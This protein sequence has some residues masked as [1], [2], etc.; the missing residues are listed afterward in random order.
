MMF[1]SSSTLSWSF[2]VRSAGGAAAAR[3]SW[4]LQNEADRANET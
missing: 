4:I 1:G 3:R 2:R